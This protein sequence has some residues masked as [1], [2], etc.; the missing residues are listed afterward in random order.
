MDG[1]SFR[2]HLAQLKGREEDTDMTR[3]NARDANT[4]VKSTKDNGGTAGAASLAGVASPLGSMRTLQS[5]PANSNSFPWIWVSVALVALLV[6]SALGYWLFH[7]GKQA[8]IPLHGLTPATPTLTPSTPLTPGSCWIDSRE[9]LATPSE[10]QFSLY[11]GECTTPFQISCEKAKPI[12]S[13]WRTS[14]ANLSGQNQQ[15]LDAICRKTTGHASNPKAGG[16][17]GSQPSPCN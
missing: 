15:L 16:V 1:K 13:Q 5:S 7:R 4:A 11:C 2:K 6:L 9:Y 17:N 14:G 12:L 10:N 8:A 3:G